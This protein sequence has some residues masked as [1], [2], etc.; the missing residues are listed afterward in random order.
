MILTLGYGTEIYSQDQ[1][2]LESI[3]VEDGLSQGFISEIIQD[4]EGFMWFATKNG[5]NRYDG[6]TFKVFNHD[7][8]DPYSI[9]R[10]SIISLWEFGDFLYYRTDDG[11]RFFDKI[12]QS[13]IELEIPDELKSTLKGNDFFAFPYK[14]DQL[15]YSVQNSNGKSYI[16]LFSINKSLI[17]STKEKVSTIFIKEWKSLAIESAKVTIFSPTN[18]GVWGVSEGRLFKFNADSFKLDFINL[19]FELIDVYSNYDEKNNNLKIGSKSGYITI[20]KQK[21]HWTKTEFKIKRIVTKGDQTYITDGKKIKKVNSSS[22]EKNSLSETDY[23]SIVDFGRDWVNSMYIDQSDILWIGTNGYGLLKYNTKLRQFHNWFPNFSIQGTIFLDSKNNLGVWQ[24]DKEPYLSNQNARELNSWHTFSKFSKTIFTNEGSTWIITIPKFSKTI[25][26]FFQQKLGTPWKQKYSMNIDHG[27]WAFHVEQ[28]TL[29]FLWIVHSKGLLRFNT[30]SYTVDSFY[31]SQVLKDAIR[32]NALQ[33]TIDGSWWIGTEQGLFRAKPSGSTYHYNRYYF[34]AGENNKSTKIEVNTLLTDPINKN[35]LWIG[36]SGNGLIRLDT[37]SDSL[38]YF[39]KRMGFPDNVI[40]GILN[41]DQGRLWM[42]TNQGLLRYNPSTQRLRQ[43]TVRDGLPTLEFNSKAFAKTLDRKMLFGSV[44][45]L[46]FFDPN[47]FEDNKTTPAVRITGLELNDQ[48][49]FVGDSTGFLSQAIEF[50]EKL[51][52][53]FS[54]NSIRLKFAAMEYSNPMQNR[55]SYYLKGA[56][57]EWIHNTVEN[58][59]N[60]F[61][62]TPGQYVL[63]LK[64]SNSDGVWNDTSL[65]LNIT[66]LPP[67]YKTIWAYILYTGLIAGLVYSIFRFLLNRRYIHYQL[68]LEIREAERL[69]ELDAFK[70]RL[71]TNITHEFRTPLTVIQGMADRL[72]SSPE[73]QP[74]SWVQKTGQVI[75]RNGLSILRLVNQL[76]DLAKL[77]AK[78]MTLNPEKVDLISF[79]KYL[80]GSLESLSIIKKIKLRVITDCDRLMMDIDKDQFQSIIHNL[81]SNAIK[82][83]PAGGYIT[84]KLNIHD[85]WTDLPQNFSYF[86]VLPKEG[87]ENR[88]VSIII[89]DSGTGIPQDQLS[90]I[91]NLF[92]QSSGHENGGTGIGL[93][94][95]K[96]LITLMNGVLAVRSKVDYGTEFL[97]ALPILDLPLIQS[98][99]SNDDLAFNSNSVKSI[100]SKFQVSTQLNTT[101]NIPSL[102]IIEDNPDVMYY[103]K[104]CVEGNYMIYTATDGQK[105]IDTAISRVPDIIISDVMLPLKDGF[106]IVKELKNDQRTSHIPIILLTAKADQ[107]SRMTGMERGADAFLTKPFDRAELLLWLRKL[108]EIRKTLQKRYST[109]FLA[110]KNNEVHYE[111][112]F[113]QKVNVALIKELSNEDFGVDHLC[114]AVFLGRTQLHNKLKALTGKSTTQYIRTFRLHKAYELLQTTNKTISEIAYE[115]GFRHLQTFSS[116]FAEAFGAPPSSVRK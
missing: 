10:N 19:P 50:T 47:E 111:D 28:D 53:P 18:F 8:L 11:I 46:V 113:I 101:E 52:L 80:S 27:K 44:K 30:K 54:N 5:L 22:L 63:Y 68:Q 58:S 84:L 37:K 40:Y 59:A 57:Q 107:E 115:V 97:L 13:F 38:S 32:M 56:E 21:I 104:T 42:S 55:F 92:Q 20:T 51:I 82:F 43:Y 17:K 2:K 78:A 108:I 94:L 89:M 114:K 60:Y 61:N 71:F 106:E 87:F 4:K 45:G 6:R 83:T 95:V 7:P 39:N 102:L 24:N 62:L 75:K 64:A 110:N 72:E 73:G 116:A 98:D 69:K 3:T 36:T 86:A 74:T 16:F 1:P 91:F 35:I 100:D 99:F 48:E 65:T 105:A 15:I 26:L 109:G 70:S 112:S 14:N 9:S 67:W 88:W 41:D 79:I 76:L 81:L 96:E 85:Q 103:L 66:I 23:H 77:E 29:D 90:E 93:A 49:I 34:I 31:T 25:Q 33:Q 12:T